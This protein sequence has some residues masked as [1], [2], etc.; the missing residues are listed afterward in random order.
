MKSLN[1]KLKINIVLLEP[2][3][4][5]NTGNIARTCVAIGARL[6]LIRPLGFKLTEK[7]IRRSGM[8]YWH[9][10][11]FHLYESLEEFLSHRIDH[12]NL[13]LI[14]TKSSLNYSQ[15]Q[16]TEEP[17]LIFGKESAG[18]PEEFLIEY[19]RQC[20]RI[21]MMPTERSLN[22]SNAVAIVSYE[23]LRQRGFPGLETKGNLHRLEWETQKGV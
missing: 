23:A 19:E 20:V 7:A 13:V 9:R 14:T 21:P 6:H 11:D 10:L 15:Y 17:Y 4:P 3:I 8:D 16:Y 5:Q 2:E 18:L 1:P 12:K 22:L